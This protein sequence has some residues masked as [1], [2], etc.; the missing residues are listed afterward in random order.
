MEPRALLD[1]LYDKLILRDL[2]GKVVPGSVFMFGAAAG[3]VGIAAASTALKELSSIAAFVLLGFAWLVSFALQGFGE[4]TRLIQ[5]FPPHRTTGEPS[6]ETFRPI[7]QRFHET[8]APHE[9]THSERLNIIKEACG[10][11]AVSVLCA[12]ASV[13]AG[14]G[15]RNESFAAHG[16]IFVLGSAVFLLLW[17]MHLEHLRRYGDF[18]QGTVDFHATKPVSSETNPHEEGG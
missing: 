17:R 18:V 13:A 3:L 14:V 7:W 11:G 1:G 8:A 2:F 5:P 15:M 4:L 16:P 12:M 9:R 10:N 6:R